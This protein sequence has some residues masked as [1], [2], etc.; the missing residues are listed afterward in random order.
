MDGNE[1]RNRPVVLTLRCAK[2]RSHL[3]R[4]AAR[5]KPQELSGFSTPLNVYSRYTHPGQ[6]NSCYT[7]VIPFLS[8]RISIPSISF[9]FSTSS[10]FRLFNIHSL[11]LCILHFHSVDF[12]SILCPFLLYIL[13]LFHLHFVYFISLKR[14]RMKSSCEQARQNSCFQSTERLIEV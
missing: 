12:V 8:Y 3:G 14:K 13:R 7:S 6:M 4:E 2:I 11:I 1:N 10:P 5:L 9:P